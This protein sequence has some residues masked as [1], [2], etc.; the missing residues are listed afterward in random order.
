MQ[1]RFLNLT[2]VGEKN[3]NVYLNANNINAITV[4]DKQCTVHMIGG[5]H[6]TVTENWD[7]ING[8]LQELDVETVE[9]AA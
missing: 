2:L 7:A 9:R 1:P 8:Q 4:G 3:Q 6:F 5:Q